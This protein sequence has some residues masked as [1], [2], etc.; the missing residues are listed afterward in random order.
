MYIQEFIW[1]KIR[2]YYIPTDPQ[3]TIKVYSSITIKGN[4][5]VDWHIIW[6]NYFV[7]FYNIDYKMIIL[8]F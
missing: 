3:S 1:M 7:K 6:K 5:Q 2:L 8:M 4:L